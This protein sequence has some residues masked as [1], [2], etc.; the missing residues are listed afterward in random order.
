MALFSF[1]K[2]DK[3]PAEV[4]APVAKT[5][6]TP[7]TIKSPPGTGSFP[8]VKPPQPAGL[9]PTPMMP[10]GTA[11]TQPMP[12]TRTGGAGLKAAPRLAPP[13]GGGPPSRATQRIVLP[14]PPGARTGNTRPIPA[15]D[16]AG[17]I[18]LPVGMIL[19]AVPPEALAGD[20]A[21]FEASGAA[22]KEVGLPM[23]MILGQLPS[24]KVEMT[25][26]ELIPHLPPGFLKSTDQLSNILG[27][28]VLLPLMDV[29]MRIPPDLLALR[30]DQKEVDAS[31]VNMADPFTEEKLR[32]QAESASE[33]VRDKAATAEQSA[34]QHAER[35]THELA[36]EARKIEREQARKAEAI[37][38]ERYEGKTKA[39]LSDLLAQR[40]LPKSGNVDDLIERLVEADNS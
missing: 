28:A 4:S 38:R 36:R 32:E 26:Q 14:T 16:T 9:S 19:R 8:A 25:L 12:M 34:H 24:G 30:P 2:K 7:P 39:E 1:G 29:V 3:K 23:Q 15:V 18:N 6:P 33:T 11:T 27:A 17:R 13:G 22:A 35:A 5:Q 10:A 31:V 40:G 20:L 37:A 21:E